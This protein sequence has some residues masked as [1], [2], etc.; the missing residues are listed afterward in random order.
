MKSS[1]LLAVLVL[2]A[3]DFAVSEWATR[4]MRLALEKHCD[5]R[6]SARPS[7]EAKSGYWFEKL[8]RSKS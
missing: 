7:S 3:T 5:M 2:G 8:Q 4:R 1:F 6:S